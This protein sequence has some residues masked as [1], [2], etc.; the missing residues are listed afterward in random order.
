MKTIASLF[1]IPIKK[2]LQNQSEPLKAYVDQDIK[3]ME[4]YFIANN[5]K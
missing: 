4:H 1:K 2:Y 5:L 3:M